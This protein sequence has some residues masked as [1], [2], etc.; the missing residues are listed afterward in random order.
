[1]GQSKWPTT[2]KKKKVIIVEKNPYGQYNK[3]R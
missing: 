3:D 1:M 2:R